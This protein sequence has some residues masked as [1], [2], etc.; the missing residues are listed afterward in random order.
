MLLQA[1]RRNAGLTK[2]FLYFL[3]VDF[4]FVLRQD[5]GA[6]IVMNAAKVWDHG[7]GPPFRA[8]I[9]HL[10]D[11]RE[12]KTLRQLGRHSWSPC[13]VVIR[14]EVRPAFHLIKPDDSQKWLSLFRSLRW[15][16]LDELLIRLDV[17]LCGA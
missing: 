6:A 14:S 2:H 7:D 13:D 9:Q 3:C 11:V 5:P 4:I 1:V 8:F 15:Q 10:L 12:I 17:T 16:L